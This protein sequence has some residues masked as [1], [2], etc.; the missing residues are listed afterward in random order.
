[1][2]HTH[3][4]PSLVANFQ[5]VGL[6]VS[7]Y[8]KVGKLE[9]DLLVRLAQLSEAMLKGQ[10]A[11]AFQDPYLLADMMCKTCLRLILYSFMFHMPVFPL[12]TLALPDTSGLFRGWGCRR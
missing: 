5:A 8:H 2:K 6:A 3:S 12:L 9:G 7:A 1:M 4:H 11:R 10:G